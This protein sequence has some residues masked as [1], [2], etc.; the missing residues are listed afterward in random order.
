MNRRS[1]LA[2]TLG[3]LA[4]AAAA[5]FIV[6]HEPDP[7][8]EDLDE[9]DSPDDYW[10]GDYEAR[11]ASHTTSGYMADYRAKL[12]ESF[13]KQNALYGRLRYGKK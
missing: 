8:L 10:D 5:P 11:F 7:V 13:F 12:E 4:G 2:R 9:I 3:A 1:F 6:R